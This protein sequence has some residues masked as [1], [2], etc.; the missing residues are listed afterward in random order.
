MR[1]FQE[2]A[3]SAGLA[4]DLR[5]RCLKCNRLTITMPTSIGCGLIG[6]RNSTVQEL[7]VRAVLA[8]YNSGLGFNGFERICGVMN[9]PAMS[10]AAWN[11]VRD[12]LNPICDEVGTDSM[13]AALAE[14]RQ[15][16]FQ[17][18]ADPDE[19]GRYP[20]PASFDAQWLK[21]GRAFNAPDGYGVCI[22]GFTRKVIATDYRTKVG[23]LKNHEGSSGSMEPIMGATCCKN[24]SKQGVYVKEICMDLD[25]KTPKAIK[26]MCE[27]E[28]LPIP[29][30][31]H[32]P[33]HYVKVAKGKFIE[34][35]KKVK[36]KNVFPPATQLRLSQQFAMAL[37]QHRKSGD[38]E[39][40]TGALQQVKKHAF[41]EHADCAKYFKCPV[42][43][44]RLVKSTYKDGEWLNEAGGKEGAAKLRKLV[45]PAFGELTTDKHMQASLHPYDTQV[46]EALN[47]LHTSMHHKRNDLSRGTTGRAIHRL[48]VARSNDGLVTATSKVMQKVGIPDD[49]SSTMIEVLG[50]AVGRAQVRGSS[51]REE[52]D[53]GQGQAPRRQGQ[54]EDARRASA[55]RVG[56]V[57]RGW[58][59]VQRHRAHAWTR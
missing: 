36:T 43:A 31:L 8:A 18:G 24:L 57:L 40:L 59:R 12:H 20:V 21:P 55:G 51:H 42:V 10:D 56:R 13:A 9:M 41:N 54:S 39:L 35:K 11:V 3:G 58:S 2:D 4:G 44:G 47:G 19:A 27:K 37:H 7:N 26:E 32:D 16:S 22:G 17:D 25:A 50:M 38:V 48:C 1:L 49:L 15:L 23:P 30:K 46:C 52:V 53:R 29:K 14:E 28:D 45:E 6:S 34:I 33:N 5:F